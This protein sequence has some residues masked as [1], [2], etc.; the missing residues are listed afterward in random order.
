MPPFADFSFKLIVEYGDKQYRHEA[1][2]ETRFN[3]WRGLCSLD[4][5]EEF[6]IGLVVGEVYADLYKNRLNRPSAPPL[7]GSLERQ[8]PVAF[9]FFK[10]CKEI[11][12]VNLTYDAEGEPN[13]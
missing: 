6:I 12:R 1:A 13:G 11:V 3:H 7:P 4:L 10:N 5:S 2:L 8:E 9:V